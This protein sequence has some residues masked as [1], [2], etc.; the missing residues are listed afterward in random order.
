MKFSFGCLSTVLVPVVARVNENEQQR[1]GPISP[2]ISD[3]N[4]K[5]LKET[6][7]SPPTPFSKVQQT[8]PYKRLSHRSEVRHEPKR[9]QNIDP[10]AD[11][12][13]DVDSDA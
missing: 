11:V 10:I 12:D 13:V 9:M 4:L 5:S 7:H 6:I 2:V 3:K 8:D 1:F